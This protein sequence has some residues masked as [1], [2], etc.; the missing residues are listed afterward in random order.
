MDGHGD[1]GSHQPTLMDTV[2]MPEYR[3]RDFMLLHS[4][5]YARRLGREPSRLCW[6]D[7]RAIVE[8]PVWLQLA[9]MNLAGEVAEYMGDY[10]GINGAEY[11]TTGKGK[12]QR[13]W[14]RDMQERCRRQLEAV[15][16]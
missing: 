5:S 6:A 3:W 8:C 4:R 1:D 13:Q 16:A 12:T 7:K 15:H 2:L 9:L 11:R 14:C 10:N